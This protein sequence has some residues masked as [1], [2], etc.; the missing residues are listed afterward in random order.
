[1]QYKYVVKIITKDG[2]K[3]VR[4]CGSHHSFRKCGIDFVVT[5]PDHGSKDLSIGVIKDIERKT[6]LSIR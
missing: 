3:E 6:G 1:M 2:W 4:T 5:V